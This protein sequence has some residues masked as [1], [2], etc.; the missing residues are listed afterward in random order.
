M[1]P[2]VRFGLAFL[3]TLLTLL[4]ALVT[5][6]R[7]RIRRRRAWH[8][9][10]VGLTLA[11]LGWTVFEAY[12]LGDHYDL[13]SAGLVFHVHMF[14]ARAATASLLIPVMGGALVLWKGRFHAAHRI[15]AFVAVTLVTLAAITGVWMLAWATPLP[16]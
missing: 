4:G 14:L 8:L 13:E 1:S 9:G 7:W 15:A 10:L 11:L 12:A 5:G 2:E 16:G 6:L 3:A